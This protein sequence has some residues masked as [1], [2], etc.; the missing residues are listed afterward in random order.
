[1][2]SALNY[3][4][5]PSEVIFY[6]IIQYM[7]QKSVFLS[8]Q[9]SLLL[10]NSISPKGRTGWTETLPNADTQLLGF[11]P[12][13]LAHLSQSKAHGKTKVIVYFL[14]LYRMYVLY[15]SSIVTGVWAAAVIFFIVI[16]SSSCMLLCVSCFYPF[17]PERISQINHSRV[18]NHLNYR[19][20]LESVTH[21]N[22]YLD[23]L[24]FLLSRKRGT[25]CSAVHS[26]T[27]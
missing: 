8:F 2:Q 4:H 10:P 23:L 1:M 16:L 13:R 26:A 25:V 18:Q 27:T 9:F 11:F 15:P 21:L 19:L 12:P 6:L 7:W 5:N 20:R 14:C 22:R 17:V 24:Y 3:I